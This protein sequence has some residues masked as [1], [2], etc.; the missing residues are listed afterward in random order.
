MHNIN[1]QVH[2]PGMGMNKPVMLMLMG[3]MM[4]MMISISRLFVPDSFWLAATASIAHL[5]GF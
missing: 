1:F 4:V 5:V 3:M 2:F